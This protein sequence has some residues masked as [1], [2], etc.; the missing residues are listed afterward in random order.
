[1]DSESRKSAVS[2]LENIVIELTQ[3]DI[4]TITYSYFLYIS[5]DLLRE[6]F[7]MIQYVMII[8]FP[9]KRQ[10]VDHRKEPST[11]IILFEER[12]MMIYFIPFDRNIRSN[13]SKDFVE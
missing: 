4:K 10:Y 11:K 9:L 7:P 5:F 8:D 12:K 6:F 2:P 3:D 13:K 1:M